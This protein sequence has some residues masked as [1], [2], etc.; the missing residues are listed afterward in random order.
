[1]ALHAL[2][3]TASVSMTSD[4]GAIISKLFD[5]FNRHDV[6]ALQA[7]YAP[8]ARLTSSDFCK[9]RTGTDVGRTYGAMFRAF[10]DIRD[11]VD[12]IIIDGDRAAVRFVSSSNTPGGNFRLVLMT[13]FRFSGGRIIEDD[14]VF[15]TSGRACEE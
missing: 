7:L 9:P 1:M 14:T 12:A 11:D 3:L 10:P 2:L 5:S 8:N 13:F 15:D 6:S 4:P